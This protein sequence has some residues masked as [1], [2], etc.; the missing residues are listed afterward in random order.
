MT[1]VAIIGGS[2]FD[3]LKEFTRI[4]DK[5]VPTPFAQAPVTVTHGRFYETEV[6]FQAR[7]GARHTVPPH[8]VNYRANLWALKEMGAEIVISLAA[9]GGI[10]AEYQPGSL[11]L[12]DQIIDYTYGREHTFVTGT[13]DPVMHADFTHPYCEELRSVLLRAAAECGM[14]LL[15]TATYAAV[16]GPRFES[17]AEIDRLEKDGA[18]VVGMTGMP[19]AGLARELELCYAAIAIVVNHAAGRGGRAIHAQEI[20]NSFASATS[21]VYKLLQRT[22]PRLNTLKHKVPAAIKG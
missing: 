22:L 6:L 12:P 20:K 17:S 8:L 2:G 4:D 15:P 16:Q 11:A 5:P 9:V 19:E 7:H 3:G 18:H 13:D 1:R 14:H 21:Q 10:T